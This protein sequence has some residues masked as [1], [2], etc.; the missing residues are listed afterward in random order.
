MSII[1]WSNVTLD[2]VCQKVSGILT[3]ECNDHLEFLAK[4]FELNFVWNELE[5]QLDGN[6]L[7]SLR[8]DPV[9]RLNFQ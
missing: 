9:P 7:Q 6:Q 3:L 4:G 5:N 1:F 2:K 8:L